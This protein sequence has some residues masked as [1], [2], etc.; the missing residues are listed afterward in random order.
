MNPLPLNMAK[1][2]YR[3][4]DGAAVV[5]HDAVDAKEYVAT[6]RY[7]ETPPEPLAAKQPVAVTVTTEVKKGK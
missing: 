2:L 6:G 7:R 5:V 3:I 1:T 4:E